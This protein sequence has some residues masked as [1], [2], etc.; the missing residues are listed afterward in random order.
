MSYPIR[1]EQF[2]GRP[3]AVVRRQA[4][5]AQLGGV[6]T[7]ACGTVWKVVQA[8]KVQGAGRHVTVYLDDV[9][10]LEIGV[11]LEAPFDGEGEVIP[12]SLPAGQVAATTHLGPYQR[13]IDAHHAIHRWCEANHREPVRPC[14]EIYGHWLDEWNTNPALIRTDVYYLLKPSGS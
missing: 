12:S 10:N 3:L 6:I 1:L 9:F 2:P 7:Q 14:W 8:R 13:L 11:E 5:L 4:T